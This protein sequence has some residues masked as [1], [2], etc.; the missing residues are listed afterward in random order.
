M[1]FD[2][3]VYLSSAVEA[4]HLASLV[5]ACPGLDVRA[6]LESNEDDSPRSV[7]VVRGKKAE[8]CFTIDG[9]FRLD[10][11]DVPVPVAGVVL[12]SQWLYQIH[13][14][15]SSPA[16]APHA[17]RFAK[18]LAAEMK[19]AVHDL[20]T[21]EVWPK[22]SLR[23]PA[24]P[25]KGT[26]TEVVEMAWYYIIDEAPADLPAVYCHL[27]QKFL[28]EALPRRFGTY[29]PFAGKFDRDGVSGFSQMASDEAKHM[30]LFEGKYPVGLGHIL[31][32]RFNDRG[33][34]SKTQLRIDRGV[35]EDPRWQDGVKRF[36]VEFS[37]A[38][39]S[40]YAAAEVLRG[41]EWNGR[42][43]RSDSTE[44]MSNVQSL[45]R[46][47][48][49]PSYPQW[50]TWFSGQYGDLV[51]PYLTGQLEDHSTGLF[52]AW[53][54]MP[55]NRDSLRELLSGSKPWVPASFNPIYNE[56][57]HILEQAEVIPEDL[58]DAH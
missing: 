33:N 38:S 41:F 53:T 7:T 16:A 56:Y 51:R 26:P 21:D 43:F 25:D 37:K 35:L 40:F 1:S 47:G 45:G 12:S 6:S 58:A 30:L 15:G 32:G 22:K 31:G 9:P 54:N 55:E 20:Q 57:G 5:R 8:Y 13:V 49:L 28:P 14:E 10:A 42:T 4:E 17:S 36:F 44:M 2:L 23:T 50:W 46:W 27:A 52:H 24:S 48:G 3:N 39:H 29:E 34:V 19:G 18:K 11:E